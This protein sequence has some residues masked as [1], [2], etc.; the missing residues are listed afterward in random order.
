MAQ[1]GEKVWFR[2]MG[3]DGVSFTASRMTRG[4]FVG[5]H[6]RNPTMEL[7]EAKVGQDRH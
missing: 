3:E 4:I 2:R 7:S 6:D 5:H 1:F